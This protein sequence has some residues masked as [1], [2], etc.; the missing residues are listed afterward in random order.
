MGKEG[1]NMSFAGDVKAELCRQ[2]LSRKCC[3]LAEA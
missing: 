3:A 1:H 2:K